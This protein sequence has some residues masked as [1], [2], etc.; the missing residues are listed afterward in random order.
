MDSV[1]N[2]ST[3]ARFVR[4]YFDLDLQ[5]LAEE[6]R[7]VQG[8]KSFFEILA[9][10][11]SGEFKVEPVATTRVDEELVIVHSRNTMELEGKSIAVDVVVVWR[12]VNAKIAE[13]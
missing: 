3:P 9:K 5:D 4:H 6:D 12:I 10:K 1:W 13:R 7:G 8:F 2:D 11:T